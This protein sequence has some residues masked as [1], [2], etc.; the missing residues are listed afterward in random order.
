MNT[1]K[2]TDVWWLVRKLPPLPQIG[3]GWEAVTT[4][5]CFDIIHLS[6]KMDMES[7]N[8]FWQRFILNYITVW[9]APGRRW[10]KKKNEDTNV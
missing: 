6:S 5:N 9:S 3:F 1:S 2:E 4:I 7:M 10:G 8:S